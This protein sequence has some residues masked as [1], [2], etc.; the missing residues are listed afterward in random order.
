MVVIV[1][2]VIMGEVG[3]PIDDRTGAVHQLFFLALIDRLIVEGSRIQ[4]RLDL[5][6]KSTRLNSS[7]YGLSRMPSSA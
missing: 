7:H 3:H 4:E 6:R 5:D 2:T 1:V